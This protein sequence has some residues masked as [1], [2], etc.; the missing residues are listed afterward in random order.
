MSNV[1]LSS[2]PRVRST[3]FTTRVEAAGVASY[4]VYNHMLL[5]TVFR[6]VMND[7]WHLCQHVQVWDVSC[8][9]QVQIQ[10]PDASRLVQW[11]TPRDLSRA[12]QDQCFYV[13]LCDADGT[14]V[15]DPIAVRVDENTWWLSISDTD[16]KLWAMGLATGRGLNVKVTEPAVWPLAVQGPKAEELMARVFGEAVHA[17]RFF[18]FRRLDYQGHPFIVARSGWSK[19]GGFEVYVDDAALGQALWDELFEKGVDLDVGPGCPN[20]VE[21][22]ESGL[23]SFGNDMDHR[24]TP[25]QCGLDK[26]CHLDSGLDSL[27]VDALRRQRDDGVPS[28]LMGIVVPGMTHLPVAP[29]LRVDGVETG[30]IRSGSF[31]GKYDAWLCFAYLDATYIDSLWQCAV[32]LHFVSDGEEWPAMMLELPFD[33]SL[34]DLDIRRDEPHY[35][36]RRASA[37]LGE[38]VA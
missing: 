9:R 33:F 28:R 19:Q 29:A 24:H 8:E 22:M 16:V 14:L 5:A 20:Q 23:L 36:Q 10:G 34:V 15:N 32:S 30:D 11:M 6:G 12:Q 3:P 2:T 13:P 25:L 21:R 37:D 38:R 4:T 1:V 18:R 27:S 31:S 26:F 17:I 35:D 7:Y